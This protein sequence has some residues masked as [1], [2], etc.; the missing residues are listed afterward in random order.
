MFIATN[1][2]HWILSCNL[3]FQ[4]PLYPLFG[5]HAKQKIPGKMPMFMH[6]KGLQDYMLHANM[7][8]APFFH[9]EKVHLG[10]DLVSLKST[11]SGFSITQSEFSPSWKI[12]PHWYVICSLAQVFSDQSKFSQEI[13][14]STFFFLPSSSHLLKVPTKWSLD[15]W[16]MHQGMQPH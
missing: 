8:G 15:D 12:Q 6:S 11:L 1:K 14:P 5:I 3:M 4:G 7:W 2:L 16:E 9:Y 10:R 13:F